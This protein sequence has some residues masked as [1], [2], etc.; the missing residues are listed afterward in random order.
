[1]II[2]ELDIL[3]TWH[4]MSDSEELSEGEGGE[5]FQFKTEF[6]KVDQLR[7]N[8]FLILFGQWKVSM[9]IKNKGAQRVREP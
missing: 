9:I 2:S 6:S 1:M 5:K 4:G 7:H 3:D 8:F